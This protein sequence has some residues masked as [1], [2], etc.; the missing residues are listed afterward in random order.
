[1]PLLVLYGPKSAER[2]GGT[3]AMNF[4]DAQG[5]LIDHRTV[6]ELANRRRISLRTGCFCNPGAGELALGLTRDEM[7]SCFR[8]AGDTEDSMTYEDFR[9]CIHH[10]GTGAVRVSLGMVSSFADA[11]A[12]L[13]LAEDFLED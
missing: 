11:E 6:E 7:V 13:R 5:R 1:V 4:R 12:F 9:H 2:R 8:H 10:E 3:L